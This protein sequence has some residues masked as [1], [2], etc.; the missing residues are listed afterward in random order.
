MY[1]YYHKKFYGS[2]AELGR[3]FSI[4]PFLFE[5]LTPASI[6]RR[7]RCAGLLPLNCLVLRPCRSCK[8]F[9]IQ[10]CMERWYNRD[11]C[12]HN[13][14]KDRQYAPHWGNVAQPNV[15]SS[16]LHHLRS[17]L[18]ELGPIHSGC[19]Q[20][21]VETIIVKPIHAINFRPLTRISSACTCIRSS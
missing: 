11:Y 13:L 16:K 10:C 1:F 18:R 4:H 5:A 20:S 3:H 19:R 2:D 9:T 6:G 17:L 7:P 12:E 14:T 15:G 21:R 8:K